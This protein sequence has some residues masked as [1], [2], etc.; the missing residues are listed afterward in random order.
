MVDLKNRRCERDGCGKWPTY[1]LIGERSR[2]CLAHKTEG[3]V[4]VK[5]RRCEQ[6]GCEKRPTYGFEG[7]RPRFCLAHKSQ[8]MSDVRNRRCTVA[9][10]S[11]RPT[12]GLL[13]GKSL[14]CLT[15][16]E[17]NMVD[18]MARRCNQQGCSQRPTYGF[19]GRKSKYCEEH[20]EQ[21]MVHIME[22]THNVPLEVNENNYENLNSK[23]DSSPS[24]VHHI[25]GPFHVEPSHLMSPSHQSPQHVLINNSA[26]TPI[27]N[28]TYS[29][30]HHLTGITNPNLGMVGGSWVGP[31]NSDQH[32]PTV[33]PNYWHHS[34]P[35]VIDVRMYPF[36]PGF[37]ILHPMHSAPGQFVQQR[38]FQPI[39]AFIHQQRVCPP[40]PGVHY[41]Y[42]AL[43]TPET[44]C[45]V[46]GAQNEDSL[47]E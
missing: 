36:Y 18:V 16:K 33:Y 26:C 24:I 25:P 42:S 14:V 41:I 21:G 47:S 2:F 20:R 37:Q 6:S 22:D 38:V 23:C 9:G 43:P 35:P 32:N 29:N 7:E 28:S 1:G 44:P 46:Y 31:S 45:Y 3:M 40:I 34:P 10:C 5:N 30:V 27:L 4:D 17:K 13:G 15:H 12:Y 19:S 39:T 11:K 8:G